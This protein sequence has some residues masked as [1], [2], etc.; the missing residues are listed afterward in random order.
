MMR[1]PVVAVHALGLLLSVPA[2]AENVTLC[3]QKFDFTRGSSDHAAPLARDLPGLWIGEILGTN[4]AYSVDYRRCMALAIESVDASG[5]VK[6]RIVLADSTK[7]MW[8]GATYGTKGSA[9]YWT[10]KLDGSRSTLRFEASDSRT[11]YEFQLVSGGQL[12]GHVTYPNGDGR[13]FL[14]RQ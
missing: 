14:K 13:L 10:G 11:A 12:R 3:G 5:K 8:N 2:A 1:I 7:N 4:V 9:D 6:A